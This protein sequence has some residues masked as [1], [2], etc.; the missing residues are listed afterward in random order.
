MSLHKPGVLTSHKQPFPGHA[1]AGTSAFQ[2]ATLLA[3][4]CTPI[5]ACSDN[6]PSRNVI[7]VDSMGR[8]ITASIVQV[9][10]SQRLVWLASKGHSLHG[11]DPLG[12]VHSLHQT[13]PELHQ[14]K[15][16]DFCNLATWLYQIVYCSRR[17]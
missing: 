17:L 10:K 2:L 11:W 14:K 5:H 16:C 3:H 7:N 12:Q 1:S 8:S 4:I 9:D 13:K 15:A 6:P